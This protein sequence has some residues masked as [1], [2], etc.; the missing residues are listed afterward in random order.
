MFPPTV[1]VVIGWRVSSEYST[2]VPSP[3]LLKMA[4]KRSLSKAIE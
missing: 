2:S 3:G 1:Y 4:R